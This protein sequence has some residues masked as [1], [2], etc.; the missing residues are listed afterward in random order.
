MRSFVTKQRRMIWQQPREVASA[1]PVSWGT[2]PLSKSGISRAP[3]FGCWAL[4]EAGAG[5]G[6]VKEGKIFYDPMQAVYIP[7]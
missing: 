2:T 5:A 4:P 1:R 6:A 3:V 7:F